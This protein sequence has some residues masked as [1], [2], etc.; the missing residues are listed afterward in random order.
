MNPL[1]KTRSY[2]SDGSI[3]FSNITNASGQIDEQ[4]VNSKLFTYGAL[5]DADYSPFTMKITKDNY[6]D[7]ETNFTLDEAVDWKITLSQ[8][9][10]IIDGTLVVKPDKTLVI[11]SC[12]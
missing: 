11:K 3:A 6:L 8:P 4:I 9:P 2:T 1:L 5:S 12:D 10:I 7:Y